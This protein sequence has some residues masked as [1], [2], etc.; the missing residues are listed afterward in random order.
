MAQAVT[1]PRS[2]PRLRAGML[3]A[4]RSAR[5]LGPPPI[6]PSGTAHEPLPEG[7]LGPSQPFRGSWA[8][9]QGRNVQP[10]FGS[11]TRCARARGTPGT[12]PERADPPCASL[13]G[14]LG[15]LEKGPVA[16]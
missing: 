5:R 3:R 14:A 7:T 10:L 6:N 12:W 15:V 2:S 13:L 16:G 11:A 4:P 9:P 8:G 1:A